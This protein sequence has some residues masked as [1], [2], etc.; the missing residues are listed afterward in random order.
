MTTNS[1]YEKQSSIGVAD[2]YQLLSNP[3]KNFKYLKNFKGY[4]QTTDYTCGAAVVMSLLNFYGKLSN[5]QLNHK[6]EMKIAKEMGTSKTHGANPEQIA[7]WLK[8]NG[9]NVKYGTD[10]TLKMIK[11]NIRK[12]TP[13]IVE[14][15]DWGGHWAVACGYHKRFNAKKKRV[16]TIFLADPSAYWY[17]PDNPLEIT[18]VSALRFKF[19]W[20]DV[21]HFN[22]GKL[23]ENIYIIATPDKRQKNKERS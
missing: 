5:A 16:D 8:N 15:I 4:Q 17:A 9:F 7:K 6:T 1:L 21:K 3:D 20:F 22:P 18:S 11:E 19:M 14:W 12:G 10:G 23:V 13:V 2:Y